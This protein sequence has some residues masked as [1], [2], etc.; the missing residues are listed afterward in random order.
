MSESDSRS[1]LLRIG[2]GALVETASTE[3]GHE[4]GGSPGVASPMASVSVAS[5]WAAA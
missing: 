3:Q 5:P 1:G 2:R 4:D